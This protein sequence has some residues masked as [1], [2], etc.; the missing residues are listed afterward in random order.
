MSTHRAGQT[1][2]SKEGEGN[3]EMK[4]RDVVKGLTTVAG[5]ALFP[6]S[7]LSVLV[8]QPAQT[9]SRPHGDPRR[10]SAQREGAGTGRQPVDDVNPIIGTAGAGLRWM[11]FPGAA[12]PFGM[13]KL[14]PDNKAWS[15]IAGSGRAGYDYKIPTILGFSHIHSWTMGG[16]L[17]MPTTGAAEAGSGA[18]VRLA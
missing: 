16:L 2:G 11:M 14:S 6:A 18:R 4:R 17:M 13:V 1:F 7:T 10:T 3:R 15:G 5:G 12:M 8:Q 9:A